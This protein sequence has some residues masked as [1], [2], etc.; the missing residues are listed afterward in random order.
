M[1]HSYLELFISH[2]QWICLIF[3]TVNDVSGFEV[4]TQQDHDFFIPQGGRF[5]LSL[6]SLSSLWHFHQ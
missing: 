6:K 4:K 3:D 1:F 2:D 5:K